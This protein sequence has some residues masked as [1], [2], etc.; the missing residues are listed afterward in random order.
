[1]IESTKR[2][3]SCVS[4]SDDQLIRDSDP[5]KVLD[6]YYDSLEAIIQPQLLG[7]I[8]LDDF[9]L[10]KTLETINISGSIE[11]TKNNQSFR[12]SNPLILLNNYEYQNIQS[13]TTESN[14]ILFIENLTVFTQM[15]FDKFALEQRYLD[16]IHS[17]KI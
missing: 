3:L 2:E 5:S 14:K 9:G 15:V 8:D 4:F 13:I 12:L 1:M 7:F 11:I 10:I 6:L 17:W 16:N